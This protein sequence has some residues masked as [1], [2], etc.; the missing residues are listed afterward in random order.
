[1]KEKHP[2]HFYNEE[3]VI[4]NQNFQKQGGAIPWTPAYTLGHTGLIPGLETK[5]PQATGCA[6][7]P[8]KTAGRVYLSIPLGCV[9][10]HMLSNKHWSL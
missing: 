8:R 6:P 7:H 5:T 1:M 2:L 9:V 10:P 4:Q 3:V